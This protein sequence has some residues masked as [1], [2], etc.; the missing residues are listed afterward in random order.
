MDAIPLTSHVFLKVLALGMNRR[1]NFPSVWK[2][3]TPSLEIIALPFAPEAI[4]PDA[5]SIYFEQCPTL[6]RWPIQY[7]PYESS[8]GPGFPTVLPFGFFPIQKAKELSKFRA[9]I[10]FL[11][12]TPRPGQD[13]MVIADTSPYFS[14]T[15]LFMIQWRQQVK[16]AQ[17][18]E[19]EETQKRRRQEKRRINTQQRRDTHKKI[20][21]QK[22]AEEKRKGKQKATDEQLE[23]EE[24]WLSEEELDQFEEQKK[25]EEK[26]KGKQKATDEQ[27]E[28]WLKEQQERWVEEQM[29]HIGAQEH[30][31]QQFQQQQFHWQ[32]ETPYYSGR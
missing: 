9:T 18:R 10:T 19:K 26:R 16:E 32:D 24:P 15:K 4:S 22:K 6:D 7:G 21:E 3:I 17:L 5:N 14:S 30:E 11:L 13:G 12:H 2:A 1:V 29:E 8:G 23:T 28:R 25:A 27:Q 31:P 20:E